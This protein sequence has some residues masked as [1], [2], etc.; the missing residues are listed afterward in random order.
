MIA[1]PPRLVLALSVAAALAAPATT[2]A[3]P[4]GESPAAE[5]SIRLQILEDELRE[6]RGELEVQRFNTREL[7][8][9]L[10]ELREAQGLEPASPAAPAAPGS[11]GDPAFGGDG[12]ATARSDDAGADEGTLDGAPAGPA[13]VLDTPTLE[14][15]PGR[16]DAT[17][18]RGS[19]DRGLA[20]LQAGRYGD[21][22]AELEGFVAAN[23]Q[24]PRAPEAAFWAAETLFV[25]G[26]YT[27][28]AA[29]FAENYRGFG[30]DAPRAP[31]SLLKVA[32][33]LTEMGDTNRACRTLEA[34]ALRHD[35]LSRSLE[36][37][38][39]RARDRAG[40]G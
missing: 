10:N 4:Q 29:A 12:T 30:A 38:A 2:R 40:C 23:P 21:A 39:D 28:A 27:A 37:A 13:T 8:R 25:E 32:L 24:D 11:A 26:E 20:L 7:Q 5:L 17:P 9:Q 34:L 18:A 14:G 22:R 3:Q 15:E 6:L 31:D 19:Y 35:D 16:D 33:A 1:T 36:A